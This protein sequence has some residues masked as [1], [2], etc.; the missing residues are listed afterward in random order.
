MRES[1]NRPFVGR[2]APFA[3]RLPRLGA[4]RSPTK[5][6]GG[7]WALAVMRHYRMCLC[8][9]FALIAWDS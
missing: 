3:Q 8:V 1:T 2:E 5:V 6:G 4:L 7:I 9:S